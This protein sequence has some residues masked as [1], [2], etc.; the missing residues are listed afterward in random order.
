MAV[1]DDV[2]A[3]CIE[4]ETEIGYFRDHIRN[5]HEPWWPVGDVGYDD[6]KSI[7]DPQSDVIVT[8]T[9]ELELLVT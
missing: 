7:A 6:F 2:I 3:K 5:A 8:L 1:T 4:I 9:D